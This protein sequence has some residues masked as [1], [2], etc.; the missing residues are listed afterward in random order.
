MFQKKQIQ[1]VW[2]HMTV[3]FNLPCMV[4]S[5]LF[6]SGT[7]HTDYVRQSFVMSIADI[8]EFLHYFTGLLADFP[9][10]ISRSQSGI[11]DV[12]N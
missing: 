5:T 10:F 1:K 2:N 7:T 9:P 4:G 8:D 12:G 6:V 3:Y 11:P